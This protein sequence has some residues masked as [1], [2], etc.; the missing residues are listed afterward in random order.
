MN[1]YRRVFVGIARA[2]RYVSCCKMFSMQSKMIRNCVRR[3]LSKVLSILKNL[4]SPLVHAHKR[5]V[6]YIKL[7]L[8]RSL[9][10]E[11]LMF[12]SR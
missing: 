12:E 10:F 6:Q 1:K 4:S 2:P 11:S 5:N 8:A 3:L 9:M 7:S